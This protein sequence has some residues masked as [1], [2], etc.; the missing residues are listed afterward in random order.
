M[1]LEYWIPLA[2]LIGMAIG[3]ALGIF[4]ERRAW[5]E[6]AATTHRVVLDKTIYLVTEVEER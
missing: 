1:S 4:S 3:A 5:T 2:V 6:A